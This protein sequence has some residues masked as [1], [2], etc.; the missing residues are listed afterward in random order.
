LVFSSNNILYFWGTT[1]ESR[2]VFVAI[3]SRDYKRT[4]NNKLEKSVL[5]QN[6]LFP[7]VEKYRIKMEY[8][9]SFIATVER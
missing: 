2:Y 3:I 9:Y 6:A 1:A 5:N 8:Q 7:Y 4:Q